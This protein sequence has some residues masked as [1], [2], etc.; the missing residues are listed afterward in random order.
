MRRA[1]FNF[2]RL[3]LSGPKRLVYNGP[4][5]GDGDTPKISYLSPAFTTVPPCRAL[6]TVSRGGT[7]VE[8]S[9]R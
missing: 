1:F 6:E 7:I 2:A 8:G 5:D 9:H 3:S 4:I